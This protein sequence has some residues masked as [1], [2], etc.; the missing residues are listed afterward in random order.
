MKKN[1]FKDPIALNIGYL[2]L[3][4]FVLSLQV[5]IILVFIYQ[6]IPLKMAPITEG[7]PPALLQFFKPNRNHFFYHA[8][9]ATSI[10]G[11]AIALFMYR[12]RLSLPDLAGGIREFL[13]CEIV[14][15]SW[16]LFA[17]FKILQYENPWW[18]RVLL[19]AGFAAA[20]L[21]KI[22]WP[23]FKRG[24]KSLK[25]GMSRDIPA[26]WRILADAGIIMILLLTIAIPDTQ[27]AILRMTFIDNINHFDQWL[28]APLWA[29]HK[30]L[31]PALQVFNPLNWGVPVL[32]H[33]LV[34]IIGGVT[35]GHVITV[36]CFLAIV[37]YTVFY[38]FLRFWLGGLPAAFGVLLAVK[39]Q[40]FH[41]GVN[42]LIWIFP[43]QSVLRHFFDV[44]VFFCL[45]LFARGR[46]ELFLWLASAA[47]G[48]SLG[49]VFDTG[50]YMAG[51]LYAYLAVLAMFK[52]TRCLLCPT[53]R[54]W[55]KILGLVLLPWFL[56]FVV[57]VF[58]F[59]LSVMH[60]EF[61]TESFKDIPRWLNGFGAIS[62]YSC[63][64]DRNFFAFFV[65]FVP[66]LI[67]AAGAAITVSM[68]TFRR[69]SCEK[70]ILI[71]LSVYG[72]GVYAHFLW[73]ASINYL[74]YGPLAF[75]GLHVFLG[76]AGYRRA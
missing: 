59:G 60:R 27:K 48:I 37:Y 12:K 39:L 38:Y 43:G 22:F 72:M 76:D 18:A 2:S 55:R 66:P 53:P 45:L 71:P 65:S 3:L 75:G 10:I 32:I 50:V 9:I 74:L 51:A 6:F 7:V 68:V 63:L 52:E 62:I 64:R 67:Y 47:V 11:Q 23:E 58:C 33:P 46:G 19:Y 69:W 35:Y 26:S 25:A 1:L 54:G 44:G 28:M 42:P 61:W 41:S 13:I 17:V 36:L 73:H 70:L 5:L 31:I 24:L 4:V 15:V 21:A 14:W 57:L 56:M 8:F 16:Q 34:S 49:L 29:Y 40:M 30:G 20:L